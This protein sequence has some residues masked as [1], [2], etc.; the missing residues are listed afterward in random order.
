MSLSVRQSWACGVCAVAA[1]LAAG[2]L[3]AQSYPQ[4]PI[5]FVVPY[6]PGGNTDMI[7]RT[8]GQKLTESMGQSIVVENRGG[9][10]TLIGA[11][12]VAK[13]APDGYTML[14]ATST[15]LAINPHLY[16]TL[17][18]DPIKDFVPVIL[19]ARIPTVLV[20]HPS[21]PV[22]SVR[23]LIALAKA[24]PDQLTYAT[25]GIGSPA[26]MAMT[27]FANATGIKAIGVPYKGGAPGIIDLLS[28]NVTMM[29]DNSS[30][31]YVK[32]G[33]LRAL[34]QTGEKRMP[35]SPELPTFVELGYKSVVFYPWQGVVV[36]ARTPPEIVSKLHAE[37]RKAL[38]LPDVR[39]R[40][41]FDG[42]EVIAGSPAEFDAYMKS[43]L[44]RFGKLI[45]DTGAQPQ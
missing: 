17:P 15:T 9:A 10:A 32:A 19:V 6:A 40:I 20:V 44:A 39:E 8:L 36:P 45:R 41:A 26:D 14:L 2:P 23:D 12:L 11:E 22:R 21:L 42:A 35:N 30:L 33:K 5:R 4:R 38:Q 34:A 31:A 3:C 37:L 18:Y 16:K 25:Q 29:F 1:M 7:A 24:K 43:E 27:L 13:A 28:G